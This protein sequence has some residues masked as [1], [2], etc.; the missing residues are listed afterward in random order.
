M[1]SVLEKLV[2]NSLMQEAIDVGELAALASCDL[3]DIQLLV[4]SLNG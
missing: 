1:Y 2:F 4:Y 3:G